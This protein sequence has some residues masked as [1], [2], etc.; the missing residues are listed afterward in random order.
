MEE[1][2]RKDESTIFHF[3]N[4]FNITSLTDLSRNIGKGT[5][6]VFTLHD[7]RLYTGGCHYAF[8]CLEFQSNCKPC[9]V[10]PRPISILPKKVFSDAEK[11]FETL[12]LKARIG[13]IAPSQWIAQRALTSSLLRGSE[14]S[15]IPNYSP[16]PEETF[17]NLS[18][19]NDESVVIGNASADPK[20]FLKGGDVSIKLQKKLSELGSTIRFISLTDFINKPNGTE[21]FWNQLDYLFV[22]S[23]MDNSPNVIMEAKLNGVGIITTAVGGIIEIFDPETDFT[24]PEPFADIELLSEFFLKLEKNK[25]KTKI[26]EIGIQK[27]RERNASSI[28]KHK[29]LYEMLSRNN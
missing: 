28:Q 11:D 3:H 19:P 9:R 4:W 1:E 22:P 13:F 17:S 6:L 23:R 29:N 12:R 14:V 21:I 16:I 15:V 10:A 2:Y 25:N 20:Q 5:K 24:L 26:R 27:S 7:E 8:N 18:A